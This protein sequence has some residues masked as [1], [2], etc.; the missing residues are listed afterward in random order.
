LK[1]DALKALL[2]PK[3]LL[4]CQV[5]TINAKFIVWRRKIGDDMN[6]A[7]VNA[8]NILGQ[9]VNTVQDNKIL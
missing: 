1:Y 2:K 3:S 8:A 9:F 4:I 5:Q 6:F 7:W